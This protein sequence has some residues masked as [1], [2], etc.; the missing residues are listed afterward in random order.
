MSILRRIFNLFRRHRLAHDID[1]ELQAHLEMRIEASLA[2]GM[3]LEEARRDARLRFGN[4]VAMRERTLQIDAALVLD[5]L[6]RDLCHGLRSLRKSPRFAITA[7]VTLALGI[8][9]T[10]AMFTLVYD[11]MLRPLPF[12]HARR[13]L[14]LQERVAEWRDLYPALPVS[15]N[16][17]TF[18]QQH[19]NSFSAMAAVE[20]DS[21]PLGAGDHALHVNALAATPGIFA[22]LQVQPFMGRA[23]NAADATSGHNR[24]A[25]L[26]YRLW[27]RHFAANPAILGH[28]IRLNGYPYTVIGVMPR[29]FHMPPVAT[30]GDSVDGSSQ[31]SLLVPLA[32]SPDLLAEAMGDLNYAV[33]A[34]LKPAVSIAAATAELNSEQHA[35]SASLPPDEK[36]SLS[37]VVTPWQ[38]LLVGK[39]QR[40]L[41][42][43]LA[44]VAALL[45]VGC[46]NIANLLLARAVGQRQQ[47]A[48]VV[49]LGAS[50]AEVLRASMREAA[51]LAAAG[52]LGGL[53]LA[54]ALLPLMRHFLPPA[55]DFRRSLHL[56]V[57]GAACAIALAMF[58]TLLAGVAPAWMSSR[59]APRD[60]LHSESRLASES[61][62]SRRVRRVLV[63]VEVAVSV[64]LLLMTG[65]V[66]ASVMHLMRVDRGFTVA[67]TLTA[68]I[69]LPQQ[70]YSD[71]QHRVAFYKTML[72]S[73]NQLPGVRAAAITNVLP[74]SGDGWGDSVRITGDTRTWT[75]LPEEQFRWVSPQYFTAIHLHLLAGR[76]IRPEDQG[77]NVAVIS[78][79]TARTLWKGKNPVGQQF[80]R[81]GLPD[82]R[83]FTVIGITA[84][85]HTVSL[86]SPDPMFVYVPYW[87]RCGVVAGLIVRAYQDPAT[88]AADIRKAIWR[89]DPGV[90]IPA[91]H[92]LGGLVADSYANQRFEMDLLLLFA[93]CAVLL[94]ALGV[95]GVVSYSVV[96]RQREIALRLAL[97]ARQAHVYR[98]VLWEGLLPVLGGIGSGLIAAFILAHTLQSLLFEVSPYDPVTAIAAVCLLFFIG[99]AACLL[100]AS[101][102][103]RLELAGVLREQ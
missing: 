85:A 90:A 18:W 11:V 1:A 83:P 29:S 19:S 36:V 22:V 73:L 87:Y 57:A 43:L 49:A 86:S 70:S 50:R 26:T 75:Q 55:L 82:E 72:A 66:T 35:I 102:S 46:V 6:W 28:I 68:S 20:R 17:F 4:P 100:P 47:M 59:T 5:K 27:Q 101:K 76:F 34:R 16:H 14:F 2:S 77:R 48:V 32:F 15:A 81:G 54:A 60:V 74:M 103:L 30:L 40:P 12:A 8:G 69:E 96:Q 62:V 13:I 25:I 10:T 56:D 42:L 21:F 89:L 33:L 84:D 38:Q 65:L 99:A 39:D 44:A 7:V 64:A 93:V 88:M 9:A 71:T 53:L 41:L 94:A 92:S 67:R 95:Y 3:S 23:F 63:G 52:G 58:T 91:V 78:E 97:G 80:H 31:L 24:V 79:R 98:I 51:I 61:R 37:V 45:L